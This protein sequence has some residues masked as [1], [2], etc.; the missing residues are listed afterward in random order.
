MNEKDLEDLLRAMPLK[1][2]T[3]LPDSLPKHQAK[4]Y[5]VPGTVLTILR[6]RIPL[7]AAAAAVALAIV[8]SAY[9]QQEGKTPA[10]GAVV[11]RRR[12]GA[13]ALPAGPSGLEPG[14]KEGSGVK[15]AEGRQGRPTPAPAA[16]VAQEG[17]WKL[18]ERYQRMLLAAVESQRSQVF[19]RRRR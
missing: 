13:T 15:T 19:G 12:D 10:G 4:G 2:P 7:W 3:A 16:G 6:M 11:S 8:T 14:P 9:W 5:S 17:F 18:P 1:K